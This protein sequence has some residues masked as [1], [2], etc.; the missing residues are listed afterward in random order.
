M[1]RATKR[2]QERRNRTPDE[3]VTDKTAF[4]QVA[5]FRTSVRLRTSEKVVFRTSEKGRTSDAGSNLLRRKCR[6][7]ENFRTSEMGVGWGRDLSPKLD[8]GRKI[9]TW[10]T[11][12]K[13]EKEKLGLRNAN[14]GRS[15][16][17]ASDPWIKTNKTTQNPTREQ[18]LGMAIFLWGFL[19]WGRTKQKEARI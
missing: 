19:N 13:G 17:I 15:T 7:S 14:G 3:E 16:S 2:A 11:K 5:G 8:F 4:A 12:L 1:S 9:S 18:I 6:K 10:R